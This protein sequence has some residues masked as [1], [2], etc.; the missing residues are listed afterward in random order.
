MGELALSAPGELQ[1]PHHFIQSWNAR[2]RVPLALE[3]F[4]F[5]TPHSQNTLA[6]MVA[7]HIDWGILGLV[8]HNLLVLISATESYLSGLHPREPTPIDPNHLDSY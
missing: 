4:V 2:P 8:V 1:V 6:S 3:T 7:A 5:W